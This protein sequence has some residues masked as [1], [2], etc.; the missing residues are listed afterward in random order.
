MGAHLLQDKL[1][2]CRDL[3]STFLCMHKVTH[4]EIQ[5]SMGFLSFACA[6]VVPGQ[7]FLHR[8]IDLIVGVRKPHSLIRLSKEM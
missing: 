5:S 4:Q 1:D 6:V 8:L 3:L 2:E 7:A